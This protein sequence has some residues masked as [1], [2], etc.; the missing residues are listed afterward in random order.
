MM[1]YINSI[2]SWSNKLS[3]RKKK[4][5]LIA[6]FMAAP[7]EMLIIIGVWKGVKRFAKVER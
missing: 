1:K 7:I 5:V 2:L 4:L 6:L 3:P